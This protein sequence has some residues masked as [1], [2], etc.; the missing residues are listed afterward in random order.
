MNFQEANPKKSSTAPTRRHWS[1]ISE[2]TSDWRCWH[3]RNYLMPKQQLHANK[4][5]EKSYE[6]TPDPEIVRRTAR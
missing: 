1:T 6:N 3:E 5:Q 4:Q 2:R